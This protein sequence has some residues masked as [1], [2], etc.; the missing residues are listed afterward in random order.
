MVSVTDGWMVVPIWMSPS[1][2]MYHFVKIKGKRE[3]SHKRYGT[4]II[5]N[6]T[7]F[8]ALFLVANQGCACHQFGSSSGEDGHGHLGDKD[9]FVILAKLSLAEI[10]KRR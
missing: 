1:N 4:S 9:F 7:A 5:R 3:P 10:E 8:R 2:G 6:V